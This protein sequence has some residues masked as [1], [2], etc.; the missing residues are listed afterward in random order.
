MFFLLIN[1]V[2]IFLK[3]KLNP[4]KNPSFQKM[5]PSEPVGSLINIDD[6]CIKT[7]DSFSKQ[8]LRIKLFHDRNFHLKTVVLNRWKKHKQLSL[9]RMCSSSNGE[10]LL[11]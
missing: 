3:G 9:R 8:L 10:L 1:I 11:R 6:W 5:T 7:D 4:S 2:Q